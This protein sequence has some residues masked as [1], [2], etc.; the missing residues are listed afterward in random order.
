MKKT[1]GTLSSALLIGLASSA[2]Q[3]SENPFAMQELASGYQLTQ[4]NTTTQPMS[5]TPT[6]KGKDGKC[7]ESKCGQGKCGVKKPS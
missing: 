2:A 3:A 4:T 7:G 1:L 5:V 6:D